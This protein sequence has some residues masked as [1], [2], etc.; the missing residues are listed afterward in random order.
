MPRI[1]VG[2]INTTVGNFSHNAEKIIEY[3]GKADQYGVDLVCFPELALCGY[4]PLDLLDR[5]AFVDRTKEVLN[6][7]AR[8]I[9]E[10][11]PV[12]VGYVER[13]EGSTGKPLHNAATL[14]RNGNIQDRYF[15]TLLPTYEVFNEDRYF[16]PGDGPEISELGDFTMAVTLCEDIWNDPDHLHEAE[17]PRYNQNPLDAFSDTPPDLLINLAASPY[18]RGKNRFRRNMTQGLARKYGTTIVMAN[19]VGAN[20]SLIFD[21]TSL[22]VNPDGTVLAQGKSFEEDLLILDTKGER[23]SKTK[24]LDDTAALYRALQTG[25]SNYVQKSGYS[26]VVLGLSGGIDSSL[27]ATLAADTLGAEN[28]FGI[29]MPSTTSTESSVTDAQTL[30]ENLNI[31]TKK[32]DISVLFD[33]YLNLF[34][35]HF[36]DFSDEEQGGIENK[37]QHRIRGNILTTLANKYGYMP[38]CPGN[39][40]ELALG[41]TTLYGDLTGLLAPLADVPKTTIYELSRWR[42][43]RSNII[44]QEIIDKPPSAELAMDQRD[45]DDLASYETLDSILDLYLEDCRSKKDIIAEGYEED[46]VNKIITLLDISEFKRSQA[47]TGLIVTSQRDLTRGRIVPEVQHFYEEEYQ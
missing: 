5:P 28:V 14:L 10:H 4:P 26:Q 23:Q 31:S 37:N 12:L 36:G 27:T 25:L 42:N 33:N 11:L 24:F 32:I 15:K 40:T 3:T 29:L 46:L 6:D 2:Q 39:K 47:P 45:E 43:E 17:Q 44:P 1:A 20:D 22:V 13:N 8:E 19:M 7:V 41:Y 16:E 35:E 38:L 9:P 21:G 30:A 18:R 34:S